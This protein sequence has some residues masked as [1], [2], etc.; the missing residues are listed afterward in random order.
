MGD[1]VYG[2]PLRSPF[3]SALVVFHRL[4]RGRGFLRG[5]CMRVSSLTV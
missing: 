1:E 3:C 4:L 5:F 2:V